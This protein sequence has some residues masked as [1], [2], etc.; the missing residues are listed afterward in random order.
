MESILNKAKQAVQNRY[1]QEADN[2]LKQLNQN[3][4][5]LDIWQSQIDDLVEI[6]WAW[7]KL[8]IMIILTPVKSR[9]SSSQP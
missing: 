2:A 3:D 4:I 1:H 6:Q 9:C 8:K 7:A 5:R